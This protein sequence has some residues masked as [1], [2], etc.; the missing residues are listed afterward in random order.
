MKVKVEVRRAM[1]GRRE[2]SSVLIWECN[3]NS[4]LKQTSY[5]LFTQVV[6]VVDCC[7]QRDFALGLITAGTPAFK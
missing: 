3:L 5:A 2:N 1:N 7:I 4:S 6:T